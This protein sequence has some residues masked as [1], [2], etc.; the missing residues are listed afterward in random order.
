[1]GGGVKMCDKVAIS[2][3]ILKKVEKDTFLRLQMRG[4]EMFLIVTNFFLQISNT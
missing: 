1:M 2:S 4:K 3:Y